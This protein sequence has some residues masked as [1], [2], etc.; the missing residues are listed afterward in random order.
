MQSQIFAELAPY[1]DSPYASDFGNDYFGMIFQDGTCEQDV[2]FTKL[3]EVFNN[4]DE[5]SC[6]YSS[7][8]KGLLLES[9]LQSSGQQLPSPANVL[10][11][12]NGICRHR[13]SDMS[14]VQV[15]E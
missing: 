6:E 9:E 13:D 12:D 8:Q 1:M 7:G 3:D 2:D 11:K 14:H 5:V 15:N 4:H 10:A